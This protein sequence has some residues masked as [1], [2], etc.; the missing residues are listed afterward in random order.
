MVR[1]ERRGRKRKRKDV[2]NTGMDGE[3][4]KWAV[5]TRSKALVGSYVKKE[6]EGSGVFLGKVV[7]YDRGLYRI[8]YEDGDCEDLESGELRQFLI[9]DGDFEDG[10][11]FKKK[12]LDEL[13]LKKYAKEKDIKMG[14]AVELTNVVGGVEVF[15]LNKSN[16]CDLHEYNGFQADVGVD[17]DTDSDSSSDSCEYALDGALSFKEEASLVPPP[18]LPPSSGNIGVPDECV[19]DLLSVYS[20]LR[21]FSIPLFLCPF[22]LEDFVGS[23][24]CSVQNTLLDAI[25]VALMRALRR[26][27]ETLSLDGSDLASKFLRSM[28]WSL[29]DHV[30]WPVFFSSI[31]DDDGIYRWA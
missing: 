21:S 17:A 19:A 14:N 10:L 11:L 5:E 13:I 16:I 15:S 3:L 1:V 30:T 22:G 26:H 31:S 20:F 27:F 9:R 12:E 6:F 8:D 29:I 25:H 7:Y 24:N 23:L 18:E 2:L 4:K 28:D